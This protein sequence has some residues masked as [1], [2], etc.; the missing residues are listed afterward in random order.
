[1]VRRGGVGPAPCPIATLTVEKLTEALK[2]MLGPTM[3][4][5]VTTLA[6]L[7]NKENGVDV[8]MKSFKD[9]LPI[10]DML[11]EVSIFTKRCCLAR[12][13]C[14]ECALK[15][16]ARAGRSQLS[17]TPALKFQLNQPP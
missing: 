11:C 10:G 12:V 13:Y 17:N 7:M 2:A 16:S 3:R 4:A 1:M 5:R 15:M 14:C 9:N 6:E 8:A